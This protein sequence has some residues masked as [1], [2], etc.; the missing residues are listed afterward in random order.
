SEFL[1][2]RLGIFST[3]DIQALPANDGNRPVL[4]KLTERNPGVFTLGLGVTD[5]FGGTVKGFTGLVYKNLGGSA[6]VVQTRVEI[7]NQI[8]NESF[9]ENKITLSYLEPLLFG[10]KIKGRTNLSFSQDIDFLSSDADN[11]YIKESKEI[12]FILEKDY[13]QHTKIGWKLWEIE[14]TRRFETT[15]KAVE[16]KLQIGSIGPYIELDHRDHLFSPRQ[17]SY[18]RFAIEYASPGY[19]SS[20][21]IHFGRA[22][23]VFNHYLP[24][25]DTKRL[26]FAYSLRGGYV[27]N[28]GR[29]GTDAVPQDRMFF[30]GGR[31]TIRGF[32]LAEI[33]NEVDISSLKP[34]GSSIYYVSDKSSFGLVKL[35]LRFPIYED[36]GAALFYDGGA[37]NIPEIELPSEYIY[38][39][40]MGISFRFYTP[41]GPVSLEYGHKLNR[42]EGES[43]GRFHFSIGAF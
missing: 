39:D 14:G 19:E 22:T 10:R 37:V 5:E 31:S 35:E 41:V 1:L 20:E 18:T 43:P 28:L 34:N 17:G 24:L 13:D 40:S 16:E 23:A 21:D 11:T 6:K 30:L 2:Q 33:P 7:Q 12:N 3:V 8:N 9:I 15:R 42:R 32:E 25:N 29:K 26:V 27:E 36:F 38:R 4:V